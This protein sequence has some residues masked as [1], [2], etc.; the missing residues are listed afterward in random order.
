MDTAEST[1][2]LYGFSIKVS[3]QQQAIRM[4]ADGISRRAEGAWAAYVGDSQL[5][6]DNKLKDMVRKGV[7]PTLRP[8]VWME[9]SGASKKRAAVK[10]SSYYSNMALAGERAENR[11]LKDIDMVGCWQQDVPCCI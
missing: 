8:W 6:P 7:P 4:Q 9:V 5:P 10:S 3:V 2:D 11:W 1:T